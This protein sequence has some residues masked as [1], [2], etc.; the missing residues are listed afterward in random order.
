MAF[1][2]RTLFWLGQAYIAV[3]TL[4]VLMP[5]ATVYHKL[6]IVHLPSHR[7]LT[8]HL[9]VTI[10]GKPSATNSFPIRGRHLGHRR[11]VT[12][13][14]LSSPLP[15]KSPTA[16]GACPVRRRRLEHS[17]VQVCF[18]LADR[19]GPCAILCLCTVDPDGYTHINSQFIIISEKK[20][21]IP[22][23][24]SAIYTY[25][26]PYTN[27]YP[28]KKYNTLR[29]NRKPKIHFHCRP[30]LLGHRPPSPL[31]TIFSIATAAT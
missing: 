27:K 2:V 26:L 29:T 3:S 10:K 16:V 24:P 4:V 13:L 14:F 1:L 28:E 6:A 18:C 7:H 25:F 15:P 9:W 23:V 12:V 21:Q 30:S 20:N 19:L 17:T 8:E 31:A 5:T 22:V 11:A